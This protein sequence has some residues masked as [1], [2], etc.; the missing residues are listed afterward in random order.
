MKVTTV[1]GGGGRGD[2]VSKKGY[3][4]ITVVGCDELRR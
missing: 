4:V 3:R 1:R 2:R